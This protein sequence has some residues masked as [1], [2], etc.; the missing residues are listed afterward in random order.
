MKITIKELKTLIKSV[1]SEQYSMAD[2]ERHYKRGQIDV[3]ITVEDIEGNPVEVI[4]WGMDHAPHKG[5]RERSGGQLEPDEDAW[6]EIEDLYFNGKY[7]NEKETEALLGYDWEV[8]EP[9]IQSAFSY[10]KETNW[11]HGDGY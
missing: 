8:L 9:K 5:Y 10:G 1:I 4:A 11:G 3:K 7:L 6:F 2:K